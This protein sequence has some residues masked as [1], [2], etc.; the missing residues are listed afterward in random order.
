MHDLCIH[1]QSTDAIK[2]TNLRKSSGTATSVTNYMELNFQ[3]KLG[4]SLHDITPSLR[5]VSEGEEETI[6]SHPSIYPSIRLLT[7]RHPIV[8][9][10]PTQ[11]IADAGI[12]DGWVNVVSR[13]TTTAVTLNEC[14]SR[15]MDDVR[16]FLLKLAPPTYPYLHNDIHL[17]PATE[18]VSQYT[19]YIGG[20]GGYAVWHS[21]SSHSPRE[22]MTKGS[23]QLSS[24]LV[25]FL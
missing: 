8:S 12:E 24:L 19:G 22:M 4:I 20:P 9:F 16:Q 15:L 6:D 3:T 11:A 1:I 23:C 2:I 10:S 5:E 21:L 17:R 25:I 18:D 14:E 13:H 7:H